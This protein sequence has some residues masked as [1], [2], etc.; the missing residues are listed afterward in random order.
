V[1]VVLSTG[2]V[3]SVLSALSGYRGCRCKSTLGAIPQSESKS[4]CPPVGKACRPSP[5]GWRPGRRRSLTLCPRVIRRV[6]VI[7]VAR[8]ELHAKHG[9]H[10]RYSFHLRPLAGWKSSNR[11]RWINARSTSDAG[12]RRMSK[13]SR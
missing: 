4:F 13:S 5:L 6:T 2:G 9:S 1:H 7:H 11:A 12:L 10:V 8:F 3:C